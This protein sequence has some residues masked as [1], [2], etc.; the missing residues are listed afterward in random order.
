MAVLESGA[1]GKLE[2]AERLLKES[3]KMF[4]DRREVLATHAVAAAAH[5]I[6]YDLCKARDKTTDLSYTLLDYHVI[7][8][9]RR[10][11]WKKFISKQASFLKH[12]D[13]DPGADWKFSE[14]L[15]HFILLD[16]TFLLNAIKKRYIP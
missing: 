3:I 9:E 8:E 2:A 15:T 11:A 4:F 12:A 7:T 14:P 13:N 5:R 6:L 10:K 16:S 1:I